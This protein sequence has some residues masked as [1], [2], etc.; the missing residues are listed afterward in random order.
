[1]VHRDGEWECKY[2][3]AKTGTAIATDEAGRHA[4][5]YRDFKIKQDPIGDYDYF[6]FMH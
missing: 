2:E 6:K 3:R 1:M 4:D 5:C